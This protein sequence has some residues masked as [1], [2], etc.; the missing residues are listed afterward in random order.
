VTRGV[1]AALC[2]CICA[3]VLGATTAF[4]QA[5]PGFRPRQISVAVGASVVSSYPVGDLTASLRRNSTGTPPPFTML[6]A[7]SEFER[8][9][10]FESRINVGVT[11][12]FAIEVGGGYSTPRLTVTV[13]SDPELSGSATAS[14]QINQYVVDVSGLYQLP[15]AVGRRARVYA[16]GGMG[17]LR[18]LHEGRLLV[19]T[20]TTVHLGGGLQY[21]LRHRAAGRAFGTRV[22]GRYV[23][24]QGG[25]DFE[26]RGRNFPAFSLLG[27]IG[28]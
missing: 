2:T 22:E 27:F 3:H 23:R 16:V 19:E 6:Q 18:Q 10:G 12:A 9:V 17:Y 7:S 4:A 20:G 1:V 5:A 11:P 24:R 14:E 15:I 26:D 25:I 28:F 8:I 13:A 21:W